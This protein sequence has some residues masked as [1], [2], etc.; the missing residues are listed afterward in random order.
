MGFGEVIRIWRHRA[1]LTAGLVIAALLGCAAALAWFPAT[2][3][4]Q[5][6][7]VLL[8]SKSASKLTGGNPYLSFTPSLSLAA[9]VVS[10]AL[11]APAT[12]AQLG[13]R[14][15]T[16][17]YTVT[18]PSYTTSTTGSVLIITVTGTD[19]PGVEATMRA[20]IGQVRT[21]LSQIQVGLPRRERITVATLA[22]SPKATLA[23]SATARPIVLTL[24][25]GLLVALSVPVIV[26]GM[27]RRR[28]LA[29]AF[30]YGTQ[31][32]PVADDGAGA[33]QLADGWST[34]KLR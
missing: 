30:G 27:I 11:L 34:I 6:S 31:P 21:A 19:Q 9:D 3:Q 7:V 8:A 16:D 2:Y 23:V 15:F 25:L 13:S 33:D 32:D 29:R 1:V 20:V 24:V 14:G 10:R 5:A 22:S 17:T 18:P 4:S 12:T 28:R 26:D